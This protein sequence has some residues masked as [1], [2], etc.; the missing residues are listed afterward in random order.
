MRSRLYIPTSGS[1]ESATSS[2][3][4]PGTTASEAL[5][6]SCPLPG[7]SLIDHSAV[8][9]SSSQFRCTNDQTS[10]DQAGS[11]GPLSSPNLTVASFF[12]PDGADSA[13]IRLFTGRSFLSLPPNKTF[14]LVPDS[15]PSSTASTQ[16]GTLKPG[17][18]MNLACP[19]CP[20]KCRNNFDFEI[21]IDRMHTP[22]WFDA[23]A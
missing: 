6:N 12:N 1:A 15:K 3:P 5:S 16:T 19:M 9:P 7:T 21:H 4:L 18:A 10:A 14:H 20:L 23:G 17:K 8:S 2:S 22:H 13:T 11:E